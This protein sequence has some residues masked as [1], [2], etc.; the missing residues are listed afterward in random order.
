MTPEFVVTRLIVLLTAAFL[1]Y[2]TAT[3]LVSPVILK[4][5]CLVDSNSCTRVDLY[6]YK[7]SFIG[8][9]YPSGIVLW[10]N[11]A[12]LYIYGQA[13]GMCSKGQA[14]D[15]LDVQ[16]NKF[17]RNNYECITDSDSVFNYYQNI[18]KVNK[19][20]IYLQNVSNALEVFQQIVDEKIIIV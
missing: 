20:S 12:K 10:Y 8:T 4:P 11:G 13:P 19:T 7:N 15:V 16:N 9:I 17:I 6:A 18:L 3:K 2:I 14:V 1:G 5:M